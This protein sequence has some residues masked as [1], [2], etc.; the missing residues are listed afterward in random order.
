ME[1]CDVALTGDSHRLT[2]S[3]NIRACLATTDFGPYFFPL[4]AL[5]MRLSLT[6]QPTSKM[7]AGCLSLAHI[8]ECDVLGHSPRSTALMK[9]HMNAPILEDGQNDEGIFHRI[10]LYSRI[11]T[12]GLRT[13]C[14]FNTHSLAHI[15]EHDASQQPR[16]LF[17]GW[18]NAMSLFRAIPQRRDFFL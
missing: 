13:L 2:M 9:C 10:T 4:L 3:G 18:R 17:R 7:L 15:T 6:T 1:K 16:F 5:K 8:T 12:R 11:S 14:I